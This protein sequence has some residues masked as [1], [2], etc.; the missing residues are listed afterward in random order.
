MRTKFSKLLSILLCLV[1]ALTLL[2]TV[3]LAAGSGYQDTDGHWAETAIDRWSAY[4]V[5]EGDS[6]NFNPDGA[7]TRAQMAA[8]LS[9]LLNLPDAPDAGFSDVKP[10]DWFAEYIN[11]CAAAGIMLGD[12]GK[13]N[14]NEPITRQQAIVMIARALGIQPI[15]NPDLTK[16]ADAAQV[17]AYA[18]GY[19]AALIEAGI[20]GG[21]TADLLAPQANIN[22]A[23][24]VTI[25]DRAIGTYANEAG[26]TIKADGDGLILIVAKDVKLTDVPEGTRIVV[27]DGAT[28]L[29]VN[30]KAVSDDQTYIVPETT[31]DTPSGGS[32][33]SGGSSHTHSYT[34][35]KVTKEPTCTEAGVKTL[36][37]SCGATKTEE[38]PATGVHTYTYANNSDGTH[39]GTCSVCGAKVEN[40][41]HTAGDTAACTKCGAEIVAKIGTVGYTDLQAA[42]NVGG[43]VVLV[44]DIS[45]SDIVT[46]SNKVTIDLNGVTITELTP[47][48]RRIKIEATGDLTVFDSAGSGKIQNTDIL[49]SNGEGSYGLIDNY[50]KLTIQSGNFIDKAKH[51]NGG[52][53]RN[54]PGATL[55]INGG[56]FRCETTETEDNPGSGYFNAG[57]PCV[58]ANGKVTISG[59]SF[60]TVCKYSMAIKTFSD[61]V[62]TIEN[63][64]I[65]SENSGG[66]EVAGGIATV[67]NC[68]I[69]T[70]VMNSYYSSAVAVSN[71][72][73]VTVSD[74][75]V[76]NSIGRGVYVF[77][78]GG[79]INIDGGTVSGVQ[80]AVK[81]DI[82]QGSADAVVNISGGN[83]VGGFEFG[84]SSSTA[85]H[86]LT[87]TGGTFSVNPTAYVAEGYGALPEVQ[88][89]GATLYKVVEGTVVSDEGSLRTAMANGGTVYLADD[90]VLTNGLT[91]S[92]DFTL[93]GNG[94][95]VLSA[96]PVT[97]TAEN[98]KFEKVGF[99]DPT[100]S[101]NNASSVYVYAPNKTVTFDGCTFEDNQW[102]AIQYTSKDATSI[103]ITNCKFALD[104]DRTNCH[105]F[106]HIEPRNSGAYTT[107]E[108]TVSITNNTFY[109]DD[110]TCND[111]LITM[112]GP[113]FAN[114]TISG[115]KVIGNITLTDSY[116]SGNIWISDG[117][118]STMWSASN[119]FTVMAPATAGE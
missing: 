6:G 111:S 38:I 48:A 85:V 116:A 26:E 33:S 2:P 87:I 43:E 64:T 104:D 84:G 106:I 10:D 25:L 118:S 52:A 110:A 90:V 79:T 73:T 51:G 92:K 35:E 30:G 45:L 66:I 58:T 1:M 97:V 27:A 40:E 18:Q 34:T 82:S 13:A 114:M 69:T 22:R 62:A 7:L 72:G 108:A 78:S 56:T 63:A 65:T 44:K 14:P 81:L 20:V 8:I 93:I 11:K 117:L 101:N 29:T 80:G 112:Y 89:S 91:I 86:K 75:G 109:A 54:R 60:S 105:R 113:K 46:V 76:Y 98:A 28:G 57:N 102:D 53:I 95:S 68:Q 115:N 31:T 36:T 4:G 94:K 67:R 32:S 50:G 5:L 71:G 103:T 59:G 21:V 96:K 77:S 24:T 16:Y 99:A 42:L 55:V 107:V 119:G 23:S 9:R 15:E 19:V 61:S 3:A 37:C 12:N 41:K 88:E 100:N 39:T 49:A 83:I 47:Q 74:S 70:N 17:S